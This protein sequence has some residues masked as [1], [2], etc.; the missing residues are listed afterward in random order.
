MA[1]ASVARRRRCRGRRPD[2]FFRRLVGAAGDHRRPRRVV[3]RRPAHSDSDALLF[4]RHEHLRTGGAWSHAGRQ[5]RRSPSART[6][7]YNR[8]VGLSRRL[9]WPRRR[10]ASCRAAISS[11]RE[12]RID[13]GWL[14]TTTSSCQHG[15]HSA[16]DSPF[17]GLTTPIDSADRPTALGRE[18]PSGQDGARMGSLTIAAVVATLAVATTNESLHCNGNKCFYL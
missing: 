7:P 13:S 2:A 1:A 10:C 9:R 18:G 16:D 11:T 15:A 8:G 14:A 4:L 3:G 17:P 12:A 5:R 6:R